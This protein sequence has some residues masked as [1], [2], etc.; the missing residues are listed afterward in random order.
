MRERFDALR[1]CPCCGGRP[2][3]LVQSEGGT[4]TV[5]VECSACRLSTPS[6]IY[7]RR[8]AY[9]GQRRLLDLGLTLDLQRAREEVAGRWNRRAD[10]DG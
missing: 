3:V 1:P 10:E 6:I 9:D 5:R 4:Y 7:A 8:G 2:I